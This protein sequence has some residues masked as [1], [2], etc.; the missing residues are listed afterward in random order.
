[1]KLA[2]VHP[3]TYTELPADLR[4]ALLRS[5][6]VVKESRLVPLGNVFLIE[7]NLRPTFRLPPGYFFDGYAQP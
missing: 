1:M 2:I 7:T 3:D 5:V 6:R 4:A